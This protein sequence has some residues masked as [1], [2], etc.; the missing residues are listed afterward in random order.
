[1]LNFVWKKLLQFQY[2]NKWGWFNDS[3]RKKINQ[4][5]LEK[6]GYNKTNSGGI[7]NDRKRN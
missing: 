4:E 2:F 3:E 7:K 5:I 6:F 1:M